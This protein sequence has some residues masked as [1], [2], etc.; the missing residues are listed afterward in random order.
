MGLFSS[1]LATPPFPKENRCKFDTTTLEKWFSDHEILDW[2]HLA[3]NILMCKTA[4][5]TQCCELPWQAV[6]DPAGET[7]QSN[8]DKALTAVEKEE[9]I[10]VCLLE[11]LDTDMYVYDVLSKEDQMKVRAYWNYWGGKPSALDSEWRSRRVKRIERIER[12]ETCR[13]KWRAEFR[14]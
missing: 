14:W 9:A 2:D 4:S 6:Y 3:H 7:I 10:F 12:V 1:C 5:C 11:L 8:N 13:E